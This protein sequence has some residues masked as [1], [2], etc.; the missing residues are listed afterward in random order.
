MKYRVWDKLNGSRESAVEIEAGSA[1]EAAEKYAEQDVDGKTDGCYTRR[2][3]PI[4]SLRADGHPVIV[5]PT[6]YTG[7]AQKDVQRVFHVGVVEYEPQ[8]GSVE[9][10]DD[11]KGG[12]T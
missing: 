4:H 2:N 5:E 9:V 10:F 1:Y 8:Y 6:I 11:E 7:G 12:G 3:M